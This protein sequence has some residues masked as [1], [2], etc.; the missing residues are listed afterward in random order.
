MAFKRVEDA[1][2]ECLPSP[3]V[4]A[5]KAREYNAP[6]YLCFVD[7]RKAYDSVNEIPGFLVEEIPGS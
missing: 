1:L 7:L 3:R 5:E 2:T 4:L 6:L